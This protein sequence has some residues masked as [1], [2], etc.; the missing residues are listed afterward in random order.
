MLSENGHVVRTELGN[1]S[2][3]QGEYIIQASLPEVYCYHKGGETV[4]R[5]VSKL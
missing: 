5:G 4:K 3:S 2:G 1:D